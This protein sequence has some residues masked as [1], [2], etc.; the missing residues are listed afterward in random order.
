LK[1]ATSFTAAFALLLLGAAMPGAVAAAPAAANTIAVQLTMDAPASSA[2]RTWR[3]EVAD[4]SGAIVST[5]SLNAIAGTASVALAKAPGAGVY[6]VR[7]L[8]GHDTAAR[9]GD[10]AFWAVTAPAAGVAEVQVSEDAPV[11]VSFVVAPCPLLAKDELASMARP[12]SSQPPAIEST[13][14]ILTDGNGSHQARN[15]SLLVAGLAAVAASLAVLRFTRRP[16]E[17]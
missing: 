14:T 6:T 8:L 4:E 12:G 1:F 16:G 2:A 11:A 17:A 15:L 3:F 10:G 9:C 13:A 7:Q 5:F